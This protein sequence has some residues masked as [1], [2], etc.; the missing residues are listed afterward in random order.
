MLVFSLAGAPLS[1]SQDATQAVNLL[2]CRSPRSHFKS[3]F[4]MEVHSDNRLSLIPHCYGNFVAMA[5]T[6]KPH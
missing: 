2:Y 1:V 3:M 4:G 6:V 5:T